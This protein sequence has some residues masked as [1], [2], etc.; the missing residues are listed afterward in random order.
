MTALPGIPMPINRI[1]RNGI[2]PGI[3]IATFV[4]VDTL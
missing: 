2:E 4:A 3:G 1:P